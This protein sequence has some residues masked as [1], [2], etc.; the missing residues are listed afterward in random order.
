[1]VEVIYRK[2]DDGAG[3]P[4]VTFDLEPD[5]S[6]ADA[7]ISVGRADG[8]QRPLQTGSCTGPKCS[9]SGDLAAGMLAEWRQG[10]S[11]ILTIREH[12]GKSLK[13]SWPLG[14]INAILDDFNSQRLA[15]NLP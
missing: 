5:L 8:S 4:I 9:I 15:R 7:E 6:F 10:D 12:D 3:E 11:L 13:R 1:M 2:A 14:N